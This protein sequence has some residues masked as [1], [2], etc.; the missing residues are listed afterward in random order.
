MFDKRWLRIKIARMSKIPYCPMLFAAGWRRVE[1]FRRAV[2]PES[3]RQSSYAWLGC[4]WRLLHL[5]ASK[6]S[7]I[8]ICIIINQPLQIVRNIERKTSEAGG[9]S[10]LKA[11]KKSPKSSRR[12][13]V[14]A[15]RCP[16][17]CCIAQ[18]SAH[19]YTYLIHFACQL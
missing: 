3:W 13:I 16:A 4:D 7:T 10:S 14:T 15:T 2:Y 11:N 19:K 8:N 5:S 9:C 12:S 1:I 18:E 6:I 17:S